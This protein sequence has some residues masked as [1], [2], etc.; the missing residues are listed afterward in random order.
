MS[1]FLAALGMAMF[2]V[3]V[4][5]MDSANQLIPAVVTVVGLGT[6]FVSYKSFGY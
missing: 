2:F 4:A 5:S 3:G 1:K 6:L